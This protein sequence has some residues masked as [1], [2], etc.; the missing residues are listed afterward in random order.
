MTTM[1]AIQT[2]EDLNAAL[3][4]STSA[5][6]LIFKHSNTCPVSARAWQRFQEFAAQAPTHLVL[7]TITV[8]E[9]RAVSNE[10]AARTGVHHES[11]QAILVVNG[12]AVWDDSH[13]RIT[14]ETLS[15][16]LRHH[17]S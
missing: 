10:C 11:P 6:V 1:Q 4:A 13:G 12:K 3:E 7:R 5:P 17:A 2:L 15:E 14:A 9:A 16:A 8:Q